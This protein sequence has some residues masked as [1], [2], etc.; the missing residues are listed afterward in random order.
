LR[1]PLAAMQSGVEL[2]AHPEL[3]ERKLPWVSD[4]LRRQLKHLRRLIDDLLDVSR[5]SN[6]RVQLKRETLELKRIIEHS[7][8][9]ARPLIDDKGH[10]I[11]IEFPPE[12]LHLEGDAVR[13]AQ[14]FGNL[15]TN[16]AKYTPPG[17]EIVLSAA[18]E[19]DGDFVA[20]RVRD[21]G[22]GIAEDMLDRVFELFTQ[23]HTENSR[24]QTGL[25]I[26]LALVRGLVELHGGTVHAASDGPGRGAEFVVRLPLAAGPC[27]A[28]TFGGAPGAPAANDPE[29]RLR[30]LII[31]DNED[32]AAGLSSFL[33]ET[34]GHDVRVAHSGAAG[35]EAACV[36]KPDVILLDIGLPDLDGYEVA[37]RLRREAGL[38]DAALIALT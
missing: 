8:D 33:A 18:V 30:L 27:A 13:L 17:G 29:R 37:V 38:E 5:I 20:V 28:K 26:G 15:L 11:E 2:L 19:D 10:S 9:A 16:A 31:D 1:N 3:V 24:T 4:L 14:V 22:E 35:V 21:N 12:P 25:G 23:A 36:F 34:V 32:L 7:F 6:G